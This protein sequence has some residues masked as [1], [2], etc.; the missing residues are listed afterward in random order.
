[1]TVEEIDL[2]QLTAEDLAK[3]LPPEG[4]KEKG[5]TGSRALSEA[6]ESRRSWPMRSMGSFLWT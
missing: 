5:F 6:R 1:M 2:H 4:C 3:Y